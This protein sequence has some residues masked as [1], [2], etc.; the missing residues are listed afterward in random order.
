MFTTSA[1]RIPAN[2][3]LFRFVANCREVV[4]GAGL[5]GNFGTADRRPQTAGASAPAPATCAPESSVAARGTDYV[6]MDLVTG[7]PGYIGGRKIAA[8]TS[9][10]HNFPAI[11]DKAK[12]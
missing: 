6:C 3:T 7:A 9:P 11:S 5:C 4:E 8:K 10:F 1:R 2:F 12:K